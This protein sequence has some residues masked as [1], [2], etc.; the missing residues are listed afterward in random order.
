MSKTYTTTIDPGDERTRARYL[1]ITIPLD[2]RLPNSSE[3]PPVPTLDILEQ[4]VIRKK[5]GSEAILRD[6]GSISVAVDLNE[7]FDKLNPVT[8]EPTGQT[9]SAAEVFA[10][11]Y[12]YIRKKQNAS[13]TLPS[14][15]F[16]PLYSS[17][18]KDRP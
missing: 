1:G 6:L 17:P 11:V 18:Q 8:D 16:S 14:S 15:P 13:I 10:L 12:A 2:T 5:D 9:A 7:T 3:P 4:Q